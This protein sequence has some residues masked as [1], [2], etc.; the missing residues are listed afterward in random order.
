M[1]TKLDLLQI[2]EQ[3][4]DELMCILDGAEQE[5]IDAACQVVVNN[6]NNLFALVDA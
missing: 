2:R 4:Q 3:I 1:I 5:Q 6:I